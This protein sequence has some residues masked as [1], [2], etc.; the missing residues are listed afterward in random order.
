MWQGT[1]AMVKNIKFTATVWISQNMKQTS[2]KHNQLSFITSIDYNYLG[3]IFNPIPFF[4]P[5]TWRKL[6]Y[7]FVYL[8]IGAII[9]LSFQKP[10]D[11][12]SHSVVPALVSFQIYFLMLWS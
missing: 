9:Y 7:Y 3:T 6:V 10:F 11:V 4:Y 8:L 2:R 1:P 5:F 12:V